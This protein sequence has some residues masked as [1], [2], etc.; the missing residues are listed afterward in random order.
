MILEI[1]RYKGY[2]CYGGKQ[3]GEGYFR[4]CFSGF[5]FLLPFLLSLAL[6]KY[7]ITDNNS[8]QHTSSLLMFI[9]KNHILSVALNISLISVV[10]GFYGGFFLSNI[11][12]FHKNYPMTFRKV[13]ISYFI[14]FSLCMNIHQFFF[15]NPHA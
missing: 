12:S 4:I 8:K 9:Q 3:S 15:K 5:F 11:I 1:I 7:I 2:N 13:D 10:L 14:F 6:Y